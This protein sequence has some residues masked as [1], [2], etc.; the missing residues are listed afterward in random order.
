MEAW[1]KEVCN[2]LNLL[3]ISGYGYPNEKHAF[4][5]RKKTCALYQKYK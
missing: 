4:I 3:C 5:L 2:T 1:D